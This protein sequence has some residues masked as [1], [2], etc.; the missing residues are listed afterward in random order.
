MGLTFADPLWLAGL[1]LVPLVLV[2]GVRWRHAMST[3]RA[4]SAVLTRSALVA[5]V[6]MMLAGAATVRETD[7]MAVIVVIDA[8]ESVRQFGNRFGSFGT[9]E[10]GDEVSWAS[11]VERWIERIEEERGPD[12]LLGV[13]VFDGGQVA[14]STPRSGPI[15]GSGIDFQVRPGTDI[16][17]AL[18]FAESLFPPDTHRRLVLISDGNDTAGTLNAALDRFGP[19]NA[20]GRAGIGVDVIPITYRVTGEVVVEGADVPPSAAAGSTVVVRVVISATERTAG[21]L[22]LLYNDRRL[23]INGLAPGSSRAVELTPGRNVI[24]VTVELE[25]GRTHRFEPVFTPDRPESDG[26][27]S[28]N[29][30]EAFTVTPGRGRVGVVTL[31]DG[32]HPTV[33][34]LESVGIEAESV[35]PGDLPL[36][37]LGLYR[38][39]LIILDNV[40]RTE[41]SESVQ[42]NLVEY[43]RTLGGGLVMAGGTGSFGAGL[44]NGSAIEEVLPVE[45]DLPDEIIES[46]I[47]IVFVLD[48]SGSMQQ[49]PSGGSLTQQT[50]ANESAALAI[51]TLSKTDTVGVIGFNLSTNVVVPLARNTDP[52]A[53]A[54]AVRNI[55]PNGGTDMYPAIVAAGEMLENADANVKH[56]VVLSDGRSGNSSPENDEIVATTLAE[57][58]I[59]ISTISIGDGADRESLQR[60]A[61]LGGGQYHDVINPNTLPRIF[62]KEISVVRQPEVRQGLIQPVDLGSASPLL[63]GVP[64]MESAPPVLGINLSVPKEDPLITYALSTG[65]GEPLLA[66]W[67]VGQ[68]QVAAYLSGSIEWADRWLGWDGYV[69]LWSRIARQIARPAGGSGFEL[70]TTV[71]GEELV[72]RLDAFDINDEPVDLLT[73]TGSAYAPSGERVDVRLAQTGPGAY[74]ARLPADEQGAYAVVLTPSKAGSPQAVVVGGATRAVGPE[75]ANL[76][77]DVGTLRRVQER[78][79]GRLL[80]LQTP[81]ASYVYD[82]ADL[83]PTRASTPLWPLLAVW[84]LVVFV[85]DVGTRRIAWDRLLTREVLEEVREQTQGAVRTR[86]A[87]ATGAVQKLRDHRP[88]EQ[89]PDQAAP[90]ERAPMRHRPAAPAQPQPG[91]DAEAMARAQ[92]AAA[93]REERR[94]EMRAKILDQLDAGGG[95]RAPKT[96][97]KAEGK[98]PQADDGDRTSSLLDAKR[99]ARERYKDE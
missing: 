77:S 91:M 49:R 22:D 72:I 45:L 69:A 6:M 90:Q 25:E 16:G 88:A 46:S 68:G 24:P 23:D 60:I 4:W 63:T 33:R 19:T 42:K 38:Y 41:V 15:T 99:R 50:I 66:H 58:G 59:S 52:T 96:A 54:Q 70:T 14:V 81:D 75:L 20:G 94:K 53:S 71:E 31:Y 11:A 64:S 44:W 76:T 84:T 67:F 18:R 89:R 9:D 61:F 3:L 86:A 8:S 80:S 10:R 92:K 48:Q 17:A 5:L 57:R 2:V 21:R 27:T 97:P 39:D 51:E 36:S 93:E 37:L 32:P 28:N 62:L 40:S 7:R 12:D 29:R 43:V 98:P 13:V 87:R 95:R 55:L 35:R 78:T 82:R 30:A 26:I 83:E 47:A 34:A 79:G 1:V 74:E 85:F 73:V 56:V 65:R